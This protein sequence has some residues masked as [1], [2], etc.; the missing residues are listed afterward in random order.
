MPIVS[1]LAVITA[2]CMA[3]PYF[4]HRR[5]LGEA[6]SAAHSIGQRLS[7]SCKIGRGSYPR[8]VSFLVGTWEGRVEVHN[9]QQF[10]Y[11]QGGE[12]G[13]VDT[14]NVR[15]EFR[16]DGTYVFFA[17]RTIKWRTSGFY[18]EQ[19]LEHEGHG[20]WTYRDGILSIVHYQKDSNEGRSSKRTLLWTGDNEFELRTDAEQIL[21][22][23][24]DAIGNQLLEQHISIAENG[25][26]VLAQ[27]LKLGGRD[28]WSCGITLPII[29]HRVSQESH[30]PPVRPQPTMSSTKN[31]NRILPFDITLLEKKKESD[32]SYRFELSM[33]QELPFSTE[34]D[35]LLRKTLSEEVESDF[36]A[37]HQ[38]IDRGTVHS[39]VTFDSSDK[40]QKGK[41][42]LVYRISAFSSQPTLKEWN[43][44]SQSRRGIMCLD[45]KTTGCLSDAMK[46]V[47]RYVSEVVSNEN[48][49]VEVGKEPPSGATYRI[50]DMKETGALLTVE[51]EA[52]K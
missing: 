46:Y 52:L 31:E 33:D 24:K 14:S 40:W 51:F 2:G 15:Y 42:L 49:A 38:G 10:N 28:R 8:D 9:Y 5:S 41:I 30:M 1:V 6:M 23:Q 36:I 18:G 43:Y 19:K 37:N 17:K 26:S 13:N 29:L 20:E 22:A 16:D 7:A 25:V 27:K 3:D 39:I 45:I 44:D 12:G 11:Y 32:D 21:L 34:K 4:L 48:V 35:E 50:L 47:R